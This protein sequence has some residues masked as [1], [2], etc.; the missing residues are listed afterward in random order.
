M[1]AKLRA[2]LAKPGH[3]YILVG[4]SVYVL[5]LAVIIVAQKLGASALV[6]VA[7]SFWIGLVVSFTLQKLV[8]FG[9]KRTHRRVLVPQ[10]LAFTALV[11]F[12]FGV[13]LLVT[14]LLSHIIPAVATRTLAIGMTTI[15]NYYLY[16]TKI[17]ASPD[18][19]V[20]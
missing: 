20:Y 15:W 12:N 17:F 9:D 16:R 11:L 14:K 8:T 2:L 1:K 10:M 5:E 19:L 18:T 3:R 7:I 6:A 4:G 13:T